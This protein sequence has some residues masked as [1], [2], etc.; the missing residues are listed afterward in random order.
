MYP[1]AGWYFTGNTLSLPMPKLILP[2]I[3]YKHLLIVVRP[4]TGFKTKCIY[5]RTMPPT[6]DLFDMELDV[7]VF[8]T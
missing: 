7:Q 4:Q 8:V 1:I 3:S 5:K 6:C 2:R